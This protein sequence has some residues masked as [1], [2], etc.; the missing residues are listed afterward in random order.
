MKKAFLVIITVMAGLIFSGCWT[1]ASSAL[2]A[3]RPSTLGSRQV[4]L[5]ITNNVPRGQRNNT[6]DLYNLLI[7]VDTDYSEDRDFLNQVEMNEVY[8]IF[9]DRYDDSLY[10]CFEQ[11]SEE[12]LASMTQEQLSEFLMNLPLFKILLTFSISDTDFLTFAGMIE[13]K[14]TFE[15]IFRNC[16]SLANTIIFWEREDFFFTGIFGVPDGLKARFRSIYN[17][18][19]DLR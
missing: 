10:I 16:E 17:N 5:R 4:G 13:E 12:L 6:D 14:V 9:F 11:P 7:F 2:A 19:E 18:L 1:M 8:S 3:I 15:N